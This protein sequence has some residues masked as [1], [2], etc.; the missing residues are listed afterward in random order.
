MDLDLGASGFDF[1][2]YL[3]VSGPRLGLHL[4]R[5]GFDL[6]DVKLYLDST[7]VGPVVSLVFR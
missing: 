7:F 3:N 1:S 5:L 2:S 6:V 4:E